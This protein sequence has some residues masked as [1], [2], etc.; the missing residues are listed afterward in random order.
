MTRNFVLF[1]ILS[2]KLVTAFL[3]NGGIFSRIHDD[4][5][6]GLHQ[7]THSPALKVRGGATNEI[8]KQ[9]TQL[10][11]S[12]SIASLMSGSIAGA[13]GV[14]VAFPLDTLKT[15]SQVLAQKQKDTSIQANTDGSLMFESSDVSNLNMFQLIVY[16]Y[17][18][19]GLNGFFGGVKG[20]M[21]GQAI[22]KSVAFSANS[23]ALLF[24]QETYPIS[25]TSSL[26]L[27]ACFSGFVTSFLVTPIE[28]IKILMQSNSSKY[29]NEIDCLKVIIKNDKQGIIGVMK[30]GL[31]PTLAREVPSY[32]IYFL[33][34]GLL[35]QLPIATELGT[36][37]PLV[38]GALTGML[39]WLPVYPVDVV[40]TLI[41]AND[42]TEES[43]SAIDVSI[44]LFQDR[45]IGAFFDGITPKMLRAAVNHS[46]TF[47]I[48]DFIFNALTS[49]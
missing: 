41:Q 48:Y 24:L 42:G 31:G 25:P 38:F 23:S 10:Y 49:V 29:K 34:Y 6:K 36:F 7:L 11:I 13:I 16:V 17:R 45:G 12:P 43:S 28:R 21:A 26:L 40:K 15:K 8:V 47:F 19:E 30:K 44:Q 20:M 46:V 37:A 14:G 39:S 4:S 22:I 9:S 27:A 33:I 35:M 3:P 5:T 32:G 18:Q 1:L 2:Q